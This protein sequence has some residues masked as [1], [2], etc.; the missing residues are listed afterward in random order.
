MPKKKYPLNLVGLKF[1]RLTVLSLDKTDTTKNSKWFCLCDCG[2]KTSVYR[3]CLVQNHTKSCGCFSVEQFKIRST[4]HGMSNTPAYKRWEDMHTRCYNSNTRSY[5]N[6]GGRGITVCKEWH[7]FEAFYSDMGSPP[8]G[9]SLER[10][11]NNEGYNKKNCKWATPKE[12]SNNRR[13]NRI[14]EYKNCKMTLSQLSE[15][16][17][18]GYKDLYKRLSAG[19]SIE[20]AIE[21]P[22][23]RGRK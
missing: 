20:D 23:R 7:C 3:P 4:T 11:N 19:W 9:M 15:K 13:S 22:K 18:L 17:K 5:K 21:I 12:Q 2:V 14:V 16:Y 8:K 10:K 1:G 6:Y